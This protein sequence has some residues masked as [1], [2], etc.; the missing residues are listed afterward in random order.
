L[1]DALALLRNAQ[2]DLLHLRD[3][4]SPLQ[5]AASLVVGQEVEGAER[6]QTS[7]VWPLASPLLSSF[8]E[9]G[10]ADPQTERR[11]MK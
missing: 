6:R 4:Q 11:G 1:P 9:D 8:K 2:T 3:L 10:G 5:I 7:P